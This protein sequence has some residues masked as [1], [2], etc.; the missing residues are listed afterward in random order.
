M[1]C[2]LVQSSPLTRATLRYQ[3]PAIGRGRTSGLRQEAKDDKTRPDHSELGVD[4][5]LPVVREVRVKLIKCD[6]AHEAAKG[7]PATG[8]S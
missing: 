4:G 2:E 1:S 8:V 3:T 6:R 7:P 5:D